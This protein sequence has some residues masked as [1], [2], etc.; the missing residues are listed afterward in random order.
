MAA[1]RNTR[2]VA[3]ADR[4][5]VSRQGT[6]GQLLLL[7]PQDVH[8]PIRHCRRCAGTAVPC[9]ALPVGGARRSSSARSRAAA[10]CAGEV[11]TFEIRTM[12]VEPGFVRTELLTEESTR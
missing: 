2:R 3:A 10:R 9:R 5:T 1:S 7:C 11:A 12:Q 4:R 6:N 8:V